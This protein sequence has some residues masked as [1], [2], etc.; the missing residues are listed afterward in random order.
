M[1]GSSLAVHVTTPFPSAIYTGPTVP[2]FIQNITQ[3][4]PDF[5]KLTKYVDV[6][7]V[8]SSGESG[9][10]IRVAIVNRSDKDDFDVPILF[11]PNVQGVRETV[12]VYE[13]WSPDLK[14]GNGFNEEKVKTVQREEK[15]GG[16]YKLKKHSFQG[17]RRTPY[18][19]LRFT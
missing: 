3:Y 19:Y 16:I 11:G 14:D 6:S 18:R 17:T 12:K 13:V 15:F 9:Q 8:L 2:P 7:A 10:E 4:T 1:R 5:A